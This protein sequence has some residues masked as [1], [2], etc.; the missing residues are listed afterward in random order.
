[1]DEEKAKSRFFL[2]KV[3]GGQE[4]DA[5]RIAELYVKSSEGKIKVKS[6][7]K[8][9]GSKGELIV[10][11]EKY[12]DV[13]RAFEN[14][15]SFKK[16]IPGLIRFEE[17]KELLIE[18]VEVELEIGDVV[19]IISGPFKG[20]K[21]KVVN[22]KDKNDIVIHLRDASAS[23]IPIILSKDYVRKIKEEVDYE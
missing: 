18:E 10:E 5:A 2:V 8:P 4:E 13:F 22:I 15:K 16:I 23:P 21:A 20:M 11:A 12:T 14:I 9:P 7:V 6:I 19:E 1:M 17:V 3:V